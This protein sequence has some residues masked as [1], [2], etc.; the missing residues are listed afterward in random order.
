[1]KVCDEASSFNPAEGRVGLL[2]KSPLRM[3]CGIMA[4]R[5]V[6]AARRRRHSSFTKKKVFFL[7]VLYFPGM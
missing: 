7:S 3:A 5:S 1:M 4:P 6:K 2:V